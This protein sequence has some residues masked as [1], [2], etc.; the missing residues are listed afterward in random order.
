MKNGQNILTI[1]KEDVCM[2][3]KHMQRCSSVVMMDLQIKV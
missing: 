1:T 3:N 2:A